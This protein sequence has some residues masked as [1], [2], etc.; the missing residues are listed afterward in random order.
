MNTNVDVI[1]WNTIAIDFDS[2]R[3]HEVVLVEGDRYD[4]FISIDQSK[5]MDN[6]SLIRCSYS[7]IEDAVESYNSNNH[8]LTIELV[9]D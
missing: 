2:D 1:D 9:E 5:L 4:D 3:G 7:E 8:S 6:P